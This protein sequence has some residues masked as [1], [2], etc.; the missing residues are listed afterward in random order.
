MSLWKTL[1]CAIAGHQWYRV[2]TVNVC[3]RCGRTL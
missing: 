3:K 1:R 2:G